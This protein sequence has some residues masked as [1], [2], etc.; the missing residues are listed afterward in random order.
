MQ[1]ALLLRGLIIR[2]LFLLRRARGEQYSRRKL[3]ATSLDRAEVG[4]SHG[5]RTDD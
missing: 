4:R 2:A 3:P 5:A 1:P